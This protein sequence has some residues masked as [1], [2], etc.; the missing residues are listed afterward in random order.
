MQDLIG[1]LGQ[2]KRPRILIDAA[3]RGADTYDRNRDLVRVLGR[4]PRS[5]PAMMSLFDI[6]D[7]MDRARREKGADY[8]P[9]AHLSVL[10]A[11]IGESRRIRMGQM[12]AE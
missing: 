4:L 5:G 11:L 7:G 10:I 1:Q 9:L 8:R 6:E 2:L 12:G 3:C